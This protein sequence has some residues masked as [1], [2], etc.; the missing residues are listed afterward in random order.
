ML[1]LVG[2]LF[3]GVYS[4]YQSEGWTTGQEFKNG[5]PEIPDDAGYELDGR[6]GPGQAIY[7]NGSIDGGIGG[8]GGIG[9]DGD[10]S[11]DI[12]AFEFDGEGDQ[13]LGEDGLLK[14]ETEAEKKARE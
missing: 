13:D 10:L 5:L 2:F 11:G 14:E 4:V 7:A 3:Y 8:P 9:A 1:F 6:Y 12:G